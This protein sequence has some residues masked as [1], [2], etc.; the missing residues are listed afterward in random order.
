MT[1][2]ED[3]SYSA[4]VH[5]PALIMSYHIGI[6]SEVDVAGHSF[7]HFKGS[8][9]VHFGGGSA[10]DLNKSVGS[11]QL[12]CAKPGG[13]LNTGVHVTGPAGKVSLRATGQPDVQLVYVHIAFDLHGPACLDIKFFAGKFLKDDGAHAHG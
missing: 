6:P 8:F 9:H 13:K 11:L 7:V 5:F 1:D 10:G 2:G 12:V 4:A 3:G